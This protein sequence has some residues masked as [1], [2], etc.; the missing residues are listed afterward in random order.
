MQELRSA[1][2]IICRIMFRLKT[3]KKFG[4]IEKGII[5]TGA[6]IS[7]IPFQMWEDADIEIIGKDKLRGIIPNEKCRLPVNVGKA[8]CILIDIFGNMSTE[9]EI[10]AFLAHTNKIPLLIGMKRLLESGKMWLDAPNKTGYI[11][12]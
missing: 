12:I 5:D 2:R 10:L 11:E 3:S 6:P 7:V 9:I 1:L 8:K 4:E